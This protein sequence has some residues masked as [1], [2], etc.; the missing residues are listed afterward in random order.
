MNK[1]I[2]WNT[3]TSDLDDNNTDFEGGNKAFDTKR[4]PWGLQR[5]LTALGLDYCNGLTF[6]LQNQTPNTMMNRFLFTME[7]Y[8]FN[9]CEN[10]RIYTDN[11]NVCL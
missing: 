10:Q 8:N 11:E 3:N 4:L 7:I 9:T 1:I 5:A 6:L 2:Y